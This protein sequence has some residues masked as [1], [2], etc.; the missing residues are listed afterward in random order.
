MY[1]AGSLRTLLTV[2][3]DV[4]HY[5]VTDYL[6]ACLGD[7]VIDVLGVF[8]K[9]GDLFVGDIQTKFLFG[10]GESYPQSAPCAELHI[11]GEEVLHFLTCVAGAERC[12]IYVFHLRS[13]LCNHF[14]SI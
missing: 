6:F 2:G 10:L 1:N 7:I 5:V 3:V 9:L 11:G 12:L 8:L 13:V 4:A 14:L